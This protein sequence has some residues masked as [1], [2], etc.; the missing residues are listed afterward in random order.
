VPERVCV[1]V[2]ASVWLTA[3]WAP[4]H[5]LLLCCRAA[6]RLLHVCL[7]QLPRRS[8]KELETQRDRRGAVHARTHMN[9][10]VGMQ[11]SRHAHKHAD[12]RVQEV[13][14]AGAHSSPPTHTHAHTPHTAHTAPPTHTNTPAPPTNTS[15]HLRVRDDA[16][17]APCV[18]IDGH[19]QLHMGQLLQGRCE[20]GGGRGGSESP[21]GALGLV[22][23]HPVRIGLESKQ[24]G[25]DSK[26][27]RYKLRATHNM[28]TP[29]S[30]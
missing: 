21:S 16:L 24:A 14:E 15:T 3:V 30:P 4:T 5:A 23:T 11:A 7:L 13:V 22:P 9:T 10:C 26:A 8:T 12:T 19:V 28:R 25:M 27:E 29:P 20:K 2:C 18:E 17:Q 6:R 1:Y